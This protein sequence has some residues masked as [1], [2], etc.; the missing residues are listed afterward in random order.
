M[1]H[2]YAREL[3]EKYRSGKCTGAE[4][5][6]VENWIA[7][8]EFPEFSI[9]EEELDEALVLMDRLC[10]YIGKDVYGHVLLLLLQ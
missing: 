4:K 10:R 3:L 6:Q 2:R 9:S 5:A 8:G 1:D 7:F